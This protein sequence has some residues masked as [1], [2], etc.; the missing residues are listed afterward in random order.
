MELILAGLFSQKFTT[1]RCKWSKMHQIKKSTTLQ[2]NYAFTPI[3]GFARMNA[4]KMHFV[5]FSSSKKS[6]KKYWKSLLQ[7]F[8]N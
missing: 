7:C 3:K 2:K 1:W 4:L 8:F 6:H 5:F